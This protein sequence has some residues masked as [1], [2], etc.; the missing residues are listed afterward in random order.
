ML[1]LAASILELSHSQGFNNDL[2][3]VGHK[4]HTA[5]TSEL[6][7]DIDAISLYIKYE[8]CTCKRS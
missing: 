1:A 5:V 3:Y 2:F 7:L 8:S 6:D 4:G